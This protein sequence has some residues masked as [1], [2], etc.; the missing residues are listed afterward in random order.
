MEI[1][2][3]RESDFVNEY[4]QMKALLNISDIWVTG[5]ITKFVDEPIE[6]SVYHYFEDRYYELS[7]PQHKYITH[8]V[9]LD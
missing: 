6:I 1:L 9:C 7:I 5:L 3:Y 8:Y 4:F 2:K